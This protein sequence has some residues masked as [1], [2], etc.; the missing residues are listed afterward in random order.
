MKGKHVKR[1]KS[2]F[3]M[4]FIILLCVIF[5][6]VC[7]FHFRDDEETED[8]SKYPELIGQIASVGDET[9]LIRQD[10]NTEYLIS[11]AGVIDKNKGLLVGNTISIRYDGKLDK[12]YTDIQDIKVKKYQV[13]EIKIGNDKKAYVDDELSRIIQNMSLEEKIAQMFLVRCPDEKQ[14][15]FVE[16]FQPG[17]Y[18]LFAQ[19]FEDLTKD[20]VIKKI[21]SYQN[22]SQINMFIA[23]DEE[24]GSVVRVSQYLR[25]QR[26]L[27]PQML[28]SQGGYEKIKEDTQEKDQFLKELGLNL[29]LA[30]VCDV[31]THPDDF[32]YSR[33][34]GQDANETGKY[35]QTVIKQ[36]NDDG[37]GSCLKHFPGYGNNEDSH[38]EIVH[39]TRSY[40][41]IK[42][43][44]WLP[45]QKG[46]EEKANMILMTHNI[47]ECLDK[48]SPAS[49]SQSVHDILRNDLSYDGIVITDDLVMAGVRKLDSDENNAV[50]AVKA[51]NDMLISSHADVQ[52][53]AIL[54]AVKNN[55]ISQNQ[56]DRSVLRIL[57]YKQLLQ[58]I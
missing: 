22:H 34:F 21:R 31:S 37:M 56:I 38:Y 18:L 49:L 46:I 28:Y 8:F 44:D 53:Q 29:N 45:F 16:S 1:K 5:M 43:N 14:D 39:D 23:V 20:E 4:I 52:Y 6:I 47:V 32:M 58:I 41:T 10:D 24:G 25:N 55:E 17:G 36:M 57:Y 33:S 13:S 54:E 7:L 48:Q 19:D 11:I 12:D 30:P 2:S 15:E 9:L 51:G 26:F 3:K 40:E 35:V 42:D 50:K 27:S